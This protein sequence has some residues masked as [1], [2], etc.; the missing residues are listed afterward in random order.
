MNFKRLVTYLGADIYIQIASGDFGLCR[1]VETYINRSGLNL[2]VG[3]V[4]ATVTF[5]NEVF[6]ALVASGSNEPVAI[7]TSPE[8]TSISARNWSVFL[9]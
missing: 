7:T 4:R 9:G 6:D 5:R 8:R 2:G 3:I 1:R